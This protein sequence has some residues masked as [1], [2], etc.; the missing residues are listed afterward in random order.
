MSVVQAAVAYWVDELQRK[1]KRDAFREALT[2][3]LEREYKPGT[4]LDL[5]VD[6]DPF[7]PLLDAVRDA[8]IECRGCMFSADGLFFSKTRTHITEDG[9]FIVREGYGA[10]PRQVYPVPTPAGGNG[11]AG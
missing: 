1:D 4:R 8:G 7:P 6:Y 5:T 9:K 10:Q 11:D 3:V 2:K